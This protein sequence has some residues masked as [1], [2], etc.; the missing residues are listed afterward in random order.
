MTDFIVK[1][2]QTRQCRRCN[3]VWAAEDVDLRVQ[4]QI[5]FVTI[6]IGHCPICSENFAKEVDRPSYRRVPNKRIK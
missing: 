5:Q 1:T 2:I 3:A 4:D 6:T